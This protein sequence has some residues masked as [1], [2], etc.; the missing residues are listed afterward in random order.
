MSLWGRS[1]AKCAQKVSEDCL[2]RR[3]CK[4]FWHG[5]TIAPYAK[6][7]YKFVRRVPQDT[8]CAHFALLCR[9]QLYNTFEHG[10]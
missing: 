1:R 7:P 3:T 4:V 5:Q 8:F 9:I 10:R 6:R 2:S